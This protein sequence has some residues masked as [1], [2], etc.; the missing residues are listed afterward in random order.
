M[1]AADARSG[2]KSSDLWEKLADHFSEQLVARWHEP[3]TASS[4]SL[5]EFM[6]LTNE[7]YAAWVECRWEDVLR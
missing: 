6:G 1:T 7:Q 3:D 4:G 5:A 2:A